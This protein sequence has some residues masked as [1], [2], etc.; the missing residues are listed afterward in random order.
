MSNA[1][2]KRKR[3]EREREREREVDEEEMFEEEKRNTKARRNPT[4]PSLFVHNIYF[5]FLSFELFF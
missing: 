1:G 5:C 3:R 4:K 2:E